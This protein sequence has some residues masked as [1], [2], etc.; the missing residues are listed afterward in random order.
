MRDLSKKELEYFFLNNQSL[1][2]GD[3]ILERGTGVHSDMIV[4]K[5]KGGFSHAM[6]YVGGTIIEATVQGGVYS[7]V[8]NRI[9]VHNSEHLRVLR[10]KES[11]S[12]DDLT[13]LCSYAR[14]LSG[15]AYSIREVLIAGKNDKPEFALTRSQ[16]CSRLVAQS[17]ASIGIR[18][19]QNIDFCSPADIENSQLFSTVNKMTH[20]GNND[21]ILFATTGSTHAKH[22]KNA[23]K[24]VRRAKKILFSNGINTIINPING[25]SIKISTINDIFTAVSQN[26]DNKKI[27]AE[28]ASAMIILEYNI[29]PFDDQKRNPY[30]Y[31]FTGFNDV[32]S[33]FSPSE[34]FININSEFKRDAGELTLRVNNYITAYSNFVNHPSSN[35]FMLDFEINLNMIKK[36]KERLDVLIWYSREK[37]IG[38]PLNSEQNNYYFNLERLIAAGNELIKKFPQ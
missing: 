15:S 33:D 8:P 24:W 9:Y 31:S 1:L 20:Q 23:V 28:I 29:A 19:C 14:N 35:V 36:L 26:G 12:P 30:R 2:P 5:T 10:L 32:Y 38:I 4:K 34:V 6:I 3:I 7:R 16:F 18:L 11:I 22:L 13:K 17:Y 27:D 21:E 37:G 25:E